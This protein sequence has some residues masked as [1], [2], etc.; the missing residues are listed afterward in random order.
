M[1][2]F[3]TSR[4]RHT[5]CALVTG[6]QTCALPIFRQRRMREQYFP[7]GMFA[8]PAWDMLLDLYAAR[9]DRQPVSVSSLCIAA[10]VPATTALRW[11][12]TMPDDGIFLRDADPN[13]GRRIFLPLADGAFA[14]L[15][16]YFAALDE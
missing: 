1:C 14:G 13:D 4:R 7:S 8:D 10:A 3:F 2:V 15:E 16:S 9:L 6:V 11:I 5:R 12:K